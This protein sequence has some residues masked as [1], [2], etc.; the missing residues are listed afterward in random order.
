M[1]AVSFPFSEESIRRRLKLGEDSG[2]EFKEVEFR[3]DR[4][5][6]HQRDSWANGIA[7]F[8]NERGGVLLLGV[9]DEGD[10]SGMTRSQLQAV[11]RLVR[12]V[13]RDSI[14]PAI[15]PQIHR[16]ELDERAFRGETQ[17]VTFAPGEEELHLVDADGHQVLVRIA[18]IESRS[19]L[20]E[21]C[22]VSSVEKWRQ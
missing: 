20:L 13:C 3:G 22:P 10:V 5:A 1:V 15:R 21:Y 11:E 17:P 14:K 12:E 19:S 8:A 16:L 7:A 18:A 2:W 9:T 6:E 4:P